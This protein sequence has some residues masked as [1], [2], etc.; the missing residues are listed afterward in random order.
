MIVNISSGPAAGAVAKTAAPFFNSV[1][2][3]PR[4]FLTNRV[5]TPKARHGPDSENFVPDSQISNT[6]E[7]T[8]H[9]QSTYHPSTLNA[10]QQVFIERIDAYIHRLAASIRDPQHHPVP[11]APLLVII[12]EP[13]SGKSHLASAFHYMQ[14]PPGLEHPFLLVSEW[15]GPA[16]ALP[17]G[18]TITSFFKPG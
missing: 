13:G 16:A 5:E 3:I 12:G 4:H 18:R 7:H 14:H 1:S 9:A 10:Y 17:H 11:D 8:E 15:S 6:P 2:L